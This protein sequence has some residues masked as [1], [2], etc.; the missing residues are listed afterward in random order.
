[1]GGAKR[2]IV[3]IGGG[4]AGLCAGVYGLRCGYDAKLV[5]MH[6]RLGGLATSWRRGPYTFETCLHWLLGSNPERRMHAQWREVFDIGKLS[7]VHPE[8]YVR[9]EGP[10]D[11][12][13]TIYTDPDRLEAEFMRVAPEDAAELRKFLAGVREFSCVDFPEP[14][15]SLA[16]WM[17]AVASL[18][19]LP[20]LMR[21]SR[22]SLEDYA[23]RFK[24]PLVRK[25]F[26]G[27]DSPE[28]SVI[29]VI[30][31]LGWI[32]GH[33]GDY[34]IGGSQAV[35]RPIAQAFRDLGGRVHL[36]ARV[37]EILVESGAAAGVRLE[38]GAEIRSDWVVSAADGHATI[39]DLLHGRYIDKTID[40]AY[41]TFKPFPSY[42]QVSLGI[43][44]P[45]ADQPG[46]VTRVLDEPLVLDPETSLDQLSFRIFNFDPTFA[47][48]GRTAVTALLPTRNVA[49]WINLRRDDRARYDW[50]KDR[51]ANVVIDVFD[52]RLPGVRRAVEVVD[53]STPATVVRYTGN[54]RGSM[55]GW[56]ITPQTG[57]R[58][59]PMT[60]PGLDQF[61]MV[62]QWVSPGG[63]LPSGLLTARAALR[64][65]CRMDRRPFTA[66]GEAMRVKGV[67]A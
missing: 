45:L 34:P 30:M 1:M 32:G 5:E 10:G 51:L 28:L 15:Q 33:D 36:G 57:L 44:A 17:S 65:L 9:L 2:K 19:H 29:A 25:L 52:R 66:S 47:P 24:N 49:H 26:G 55:E 4:I 54:W 43:A 14:P 59:L 60:L 18:R 31:T 8:E 20:A 38:N 35:I 61:L 53:V 16:G 58:P 40:A 23:K 21:W 12:R 42:L 62:G 7:F 11:E 3:V 50:E 6:D 67:A 64:T 46:F 37:E 48:P 39:Y 41:H 22:M 13:L 27:G 56:L 63:G